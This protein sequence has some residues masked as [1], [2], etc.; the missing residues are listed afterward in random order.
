[1]RRHQRS[2]EPEN[3]RHFRS[4]DSHGSPGRRS[5]DP[6]R[7]RCS[8]LA[9]AARRSREFRSLV[10]CSRRF[11]PFAGSWGWVPRPSRKTCGLSNDFG[12][13]AACSVCS[14][15]R[16]TLLLLGRARSHCSWELHTHAIR[17]GHARRCAPRA[18]GG[19]TA[20][21]GGSAASRL[22]SSGFLKRE[23]GVRRPPK[24][25]A[26]APPRVT[27]TFILPEDVVFWSAENPRFSQAARIRLEN[28]QKQNP[29][30]GAYPNTTISF[31]PCEY[32]SKP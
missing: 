26:A 8:R 11:A 31:S 7:S 17:T 29:L 1:M 19:E 13:V 3:P 23:V 4:R 24:T 6:R 22:T 28:R 12:R 18:R 25:V 9:L 10:I 32:K 16:S 27:R 5:S 14:R 20:S 2:S 21:Q 30:L 15:A